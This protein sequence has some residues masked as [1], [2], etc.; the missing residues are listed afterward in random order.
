MAQ[1]FISYSRKD[2]EFVQKLVDAL[3]AAKREVWLDDRNIEPTAEWLREVFNNIERADN[4]VF[5]ISPDSV[6]SVNCNREIEHAVAN[7][8][9]ILPIFYRSVPDADIP[10]AVAKFQ[11]I[12]FTGR[13]SFEAQLARVIVAL[14][15]D[16]DWKQNHTRLLTRAKEWERKKDRSFLLR[17][18]DLREAEHWVSKSAEK[19]P[20][21]TMLHSQ[22]ILTS[23]QSATKTKRIIVGAVGVMFAILLFT[24]AKWTA[25]SD[26]L[27]RWSIKQAIATV[28]EPSLGKLKSST[29]Y[30]AWF[31]AFEMGKILN[32]EKTRFGTSGSTYTILLS[33]RP[34]NQSNL[35]WFDAGDAPSLRV[36]PNEIRRQILEADSNMDTI[37]QQTRLPAS[38][39][40]LPDPTKLVAGTIWSKPEARLDGTMAYLYTKYGL[41]NF[42]GLPPTQLTCQTEVVL[43]EYENGLAIGGAPAE[44]CADMQYVYLLFPDGQSHKDSHRGYWKPKSSLPIFGNRFKTP[45]GCKLE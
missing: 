23:R 12:D 32:L 3:V 18:E 30:C 17:G 4:F 43:N 42:F 29:L 44:N 41:H 39:A 31:Q 22:Y 9:K 25:V 28:D 19:Q 27:H 36:N 1:V 24:I 8:K 21:P 7:H 38:R 16:L 35:R 14:D 33:T 37:A 15:T 13:D 20:K 10:E 2:K 11:R 6:I 40:P 34:D 5:V 26:A 45:M